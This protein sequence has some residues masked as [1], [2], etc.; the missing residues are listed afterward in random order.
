MTL[1]DSVEE[2]MY[3]RIKNEN[4]YSLSLSLSLTNK[5]SLCFNDLASFDDL[6]NAR[7]RFDEILYVYDIWYHGVVW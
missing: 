7:V 2:Y 3:M 1:Y 5:L 4:L 6:R